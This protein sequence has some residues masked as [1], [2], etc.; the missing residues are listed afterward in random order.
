MKRELLTTLAWF[1]LTASA[2][3][4]TVTALPGTGIV[5]SVHDMN[6]VGNNIEKDPLGRVCAFCHTPHHAIDSNTD[7]N[8]GDYMPLWSH[9]LTVQSFTQYNSG[10][11]DAKNV[12][13][14]DPLVGP[15]RLCMSC[16][17]GAIAP[18]QH[19]G[20]TSA[21]NQVFRGNEFTG[22][23][24]QIGIGANGALNRTHPIGFDLAKAVIADTK[25]SGIAR[26]N[27]DIA[28]TALYLNT[29][30]TISS[31]L[32]NGYMTCITC[33][34]VH[35]QDNTASVPGTGVDADHQ[36]TVSKNYLLFAK[37]SGSQLC[38]SC[39]KK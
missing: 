23:E 28:T 1:S 31:Q 19:N 38:L 21:V 9:K 22:T 26:F 24:P 30:K 12:A 17:D 20:A 6:M 10:T 8:A 15:S 13:V 16:H 29:A 37:Q 32:Y 27:G 34:D 33:H 25:A 36:V 14:I 3:F 39:H 11:F 4:A 35:N 2:A 5:G 7:S 18:D